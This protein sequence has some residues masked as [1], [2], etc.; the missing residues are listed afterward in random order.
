MAGTVTSQIAQ[1]SPP[2]DETC[3]KTSPFPQIRTNEANA[4]QPTAWARTVEA[5]AKTTGIYDGNGLVVKPFD[6]RIEFKTLLI[7]PPPNKPPSRVTSELIAA[8]Q[9]VKD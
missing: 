9:G 1:I 2:S 3:P 4:P 8:L 6:P 5:E 7:T